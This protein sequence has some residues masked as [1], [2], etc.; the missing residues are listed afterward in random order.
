MITHGRLS[1]YNSG[2]RCDDCREA[3]A[4]YQATRISR[5]V[6]P[7]PGDP[8]HGRYSTYINYRCRCSLCTQANT[9]YCRGYK[10]RRAA[11]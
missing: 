8:R 6:V 2:C 5:A 1:S 3:V 11:Q 9:A 4:D 10:T 7:P